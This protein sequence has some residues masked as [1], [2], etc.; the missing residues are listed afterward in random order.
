MSRWVVPKSAANAR[1]ANATEEP[2]SPAER[3]AKYIPGEIVSVFTMLIGVAATLTVPPETQRVTALV[4]IAASFV[5]TIV[6]VRH[7]APAGAV[8][9]AH[10]WLSPLAF[11]AWAYPISGAM[12]GEWFNA[13][14][15]FFAQA[16]VVLL[17]LLVAPA[18]K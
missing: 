3:I 10:L 6:Y 2:S 18:D 17:S 15:S 5:A 8:R 9:Q 16:F 14:Y 1:A 7:E 12:L 11:L 4:L 13:L